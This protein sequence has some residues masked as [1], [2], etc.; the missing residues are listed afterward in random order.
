MAFDKDFIDQMKTRLEQMKLSI[1]EMLLHEDEDFQELVDNDGPKDLVDVASDDIDMK[2]LE[3]LG[4]Q[5]VK[6]LRLI[7]AALARIAN[8]QYG[9]CLKSG[10]PIPRERL[11]AIPY[12]LYTIEV[13]EELDR[14]KRRVG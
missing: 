9:Y 13:Q 6:R 4:A 5:E 3:A 12:A 11:E 8:D 1:L 2:T 7:E 14:Q 10:K